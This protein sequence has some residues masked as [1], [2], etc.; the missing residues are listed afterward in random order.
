MGAEFSA[1]KAIAASSGLYPVESV[2][3]TLDDTQPDVSHNQAMNDITRH[4]LDAKLEA[5]EARMDGRVASIEN[6]VS[7]MRSEMREFLAEQRER[8]KRFE[9]ELAASRRESDQ[10]FGSILR[11]VDR[12]GNLKANIW[13][14]MVTTIV[15]LV[16][17]G[18]LALTSFQAGAVKQSAPVEVEQPLPPAQAAPPAAPLQAPAAE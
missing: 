10:R 6:S 2:A 8:D 17:V 3:I 4:E 13:G 15:I 7:S 12:L 5:I 1:R 11:D 16:A 18:A 9:A 14:A